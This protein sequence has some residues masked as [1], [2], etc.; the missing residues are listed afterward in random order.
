MKCSVNL[1]AADVSCRDKNN[2]SNIMEYC[3]CSVRQGVQM[4]GGDMQ[5]FWNWHKL[6][7]SVFLLAT[8]DNYVDVVTQSSNRSMINQFD[9][10]HIKQKSRER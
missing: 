4:H 3:K 9:I 1:F 6:C 8:G 10:Q 5:V 7:I 2:S